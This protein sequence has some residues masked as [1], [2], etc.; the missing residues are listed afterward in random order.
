M[1]DTRLYVWDLL[2]DAD[3]PV[4]TEELGGSSTLT[5]MNVYSGNLRTRAPSVALG[6]R[7]GDVRVHKLDRILYTPC[8]EEHQQMER[9][10]GMLC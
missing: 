8:L 3:A 2:K 4:L 5:S 9:L 10:L 7:S 1:D 6:F